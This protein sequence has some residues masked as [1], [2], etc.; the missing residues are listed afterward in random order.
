MFEYPSLD[1]P[2][3]AN[4]LKYILTTHHL[5]GHRLS[6]SK[7]KLSK[8]TKL[9]AKH[10]SPNLFIVKCSF[11]MV[12]PDF[13]TSSSNSQSPNNLQ[14]T[15]YILD[16]NGFPVQGNDWYK[17]Q[18]PDLSEL[19]V[20]AKNMSDYYRIVSGA[21]GTG[22]QF[23]PSCDGRWDENQKVTFT[24]RNAHTQDGQSFEGYF[25]ALN[26]GQSRI[27]LHNSN[28]SGFRASAQEKN[29]VL[30]GLGADYGLRITRDDRYLVV[31]SA[32]DRGGVPLHCQ[33]VRQ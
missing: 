21:P 11:S 3:L 8:C 22:I 9:Y 33:F 4:L 19:T 23:R 28:M 32:D 13:F 15:K 7:L 12:S 18:L 17:I 10:I 29:S 27:V 31:P 30:L 24:V 2:H 1:Q 20:Q 14:T 26:V 16:S 25:V 6:L 5:S